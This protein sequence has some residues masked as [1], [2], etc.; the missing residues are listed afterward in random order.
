MTNEK[1][2]FFYMRKELKFFF[3]EKRIKFFYRGLFGISYTVG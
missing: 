3:Y 1:S 2:S